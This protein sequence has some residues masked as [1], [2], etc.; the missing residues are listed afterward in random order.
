MNIMHKMLH[1]LFY[2]NFTAYKVSLVLYTIPLYADA[3][4]ATL[5]IKEKAKKIINKIICNSYNS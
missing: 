3:K 2:K 4:I 5:Y 1:Q